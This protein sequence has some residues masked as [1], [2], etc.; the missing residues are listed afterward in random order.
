MGSIIGTPGGGSTPPYQPP[1]QPPYQ[2]P[3]NQPPYQPA[4]QQ[5]YQPPYQPPPAPAEGGGIKIPILIGAVIAL[6]GASIYLFYEVSQLRSDLHQEV[7]TMRDG[8]MDEIAKEKETSNVT[9]QTSRKTV[10]NLQKEVADARRQAS[11]LAGDAKVEATK[12][13]D[14]L[15][16]RLERV[17]EQQA[18]KVTAV[19]ADVSQV[20]D[21]TSA[22]QSKVGEVTTQVGTLQ[23]DQAS[24]KSELEKTIAD[25]KRTSGDLG[26]QS[27]LIATNGK[28]LA[29]L[30]ALGE[31]NYVEFKLAKAKTPEKVGD[32]QIKLLAA[33]PKKN[34]YTLSLIADDKTVEKKDR[35]VNEPVQFYLSR[36][37][38]PYELVVNE[39]RKDMIVGYVSAPKVQQA[40]GKAN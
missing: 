25:L 19:A 30:K 6:L 40:R 35:S 29:A 28:E 18:A 26:V 8:I 21:Q 33:D 27:G 7:A 15:A 12:H 13:A 16:N 14:E 17:Q 32:V 39:V 1:N 38:Q 11:Q 31:R 3:P 23:T 20:R 34:K 10:E 9:L 5:P 24:T 37:T 36:A 22:V 4:Y 2:P